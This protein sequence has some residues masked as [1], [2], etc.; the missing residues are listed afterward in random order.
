VPFRNAWSEAPHATGWRKF[1]DNV[2][3]VAEVNVSRFDSA[4]LANRG[5]GAVRRNK[6]AV[7]AEAELKAS[8]EVAFQE[9]WMYKLIKPRGELSRAHF[10]G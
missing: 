5:V 8:V 9:S 2:C 3:A 6:G 4:L 7:V 10:D 1:L